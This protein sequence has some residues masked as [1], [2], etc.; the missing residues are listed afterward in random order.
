[1]RVTTTNFT[2]AE[3]CA[4]MGRG[5]IVVNHDY[6]RSQKV[7]PPAAR[8]YLIDTVLM[9]FPIPKL[10][11]F[12][13]TDRITRQTV[14]EIVDGQQRSQAFCNYLSGRYRLSPRSPNAG[15]RFT[16]LDEAA[17]QVLLEYSIS[18]DILV[19]A[20]ESE[21]RQLFRRINSYTVPLNDQ[22]TRHAVFQGA[23][24]WFI[25]E[26][27]EKYSQSLKQIG[28]YGERQ[29]TRMADAQL[30]SELVRALTDG[31][32]TSQPTDIEDLYKRYDDE[33]AASE[34]IQA[35]FDAVFARLLPWEDLH[36]G[37]LLRPYNFYSLFL[38]LTHL[39]SP[40]ASLQ[41][42]YELGAPR[43]IDEPTYLANL[44]SL[45]EALDQPDDHPELQEFMDAA[46]SAT[47]VREQRVVRFKWFCRASEAHLIA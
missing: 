40:V 45:A 16:Q 28:T 37:P 9:G 24:K 30:F 8:S 14:K 42:H 20:S 12:Q 18:A 26:L 5:E 22:E 15:R 17:Q 1:V 38:A 27:T 4:Q 21:I 33:F 11:L 19:D 47:N 10:T 6:Q 39:Q 46:S 34:G 25:V 41:E 32:A 35:R 13:R 23:F 3:Y 2:I 43:E 44:S 29:L 31:I 7:W 36:R